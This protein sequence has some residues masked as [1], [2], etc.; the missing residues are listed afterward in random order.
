M[1]STKPMTVEKLETLGGDESER[2]EIM[3]G[4]LYEVMPGNLRHGEVVENVFLPLSTHVRQNRLGRVLPNDP[5]FVLQ[6]EPDILL[7]PDLA[8]VRADRMPTGENLRRF[9]RFP[10]DLVAEVLSPSNDPG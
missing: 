1:V 3:D 5:G 8:F 6:R 7:G 9:G 10:P 4:E 2:Y